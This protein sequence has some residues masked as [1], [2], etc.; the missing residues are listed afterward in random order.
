MNGTIIAGTLRPEDLIPA[1]I[2]ALDAR[3]EELSLLGKLGSGEFERLDDYLGELEQ[4]MGQEGYY[5]SEDVAWDLEWLFDK[6][7]DLAPEGTYFGAHP[8][9]G[10]DFG[11][12]SIEDEEDED[13]GI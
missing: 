3:K 9:D 8:Y 2:K 6:L 4:R 10:A 5:D 1:F 7:N 13:G 12:W 11:F